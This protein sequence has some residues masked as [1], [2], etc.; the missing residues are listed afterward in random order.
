MMSKCTV[1]ILPLF[2]S[3]AM[4]AKLIGFSYF[5]LEDNINIADNYF[6]EIDK[7]ACENGVFNEGELVEFRMD[8][9]V[10]KCKDWICDT[11]TTPSSDLKILMNS[12]VTTPDGP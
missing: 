2:L 9:S 3:S 11:C 7:D 4:E 8:C 1:V 6:E 12:T 5:I 10:C